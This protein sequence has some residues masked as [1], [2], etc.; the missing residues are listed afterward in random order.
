MIRLL[1]VTLL[2][3]AVAVA[4]KLRT[5]SASPTKAI[6]VTSRLGVGRGTMVAVVEVE[7]RRLLIGSA[8]NQVTLLAELSSAPPA[9]DPEPALGPTPDP[10]T[11]HRPSDPLQ[12]VETSRSLVERARR[13]TARTAEPRLRL[14]VRNET[15]S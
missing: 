6:R 3:A 4:V 13:A 7:G 9:G 12:P 10:A 15:P 5:R 11:P 2:L 8:P 1:V 14:P